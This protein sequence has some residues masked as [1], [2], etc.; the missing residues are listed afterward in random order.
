MPPQADKSEELRAA[1]L[2]FMEKAGAGVQHRAKE[3]QAGADLPKGTKPSA[4]K[5]QLK[6]LAQDKKVTI[7]GKSSATRYSIAG[8]ATGKSLATHRGG[9]HH[10]I[11][12]VDPKAAIKATI[13]HLSR[14][15]QKMLDT[16]ESL[17]ELL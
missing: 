7:T 4:V 1:I 14:E 15:G 5:Y 8:G 6:L 16:A 17:R 10:V 2:K 9:D 13:A 11:D 12:A 3:I